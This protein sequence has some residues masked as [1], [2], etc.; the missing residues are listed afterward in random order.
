MQSKSFVRGALLT[1]LIF[2]VHVAVGANTNTNNF[3]FSGPEIFPIDQQIG[4]LHVADM[5]GDGLNDLVVANNLRAKI[6]ILYNLTGKTNLPARPLRLMEINDLPPG[7]RFRIDS[8]PAD[9]RIS[10]M[11]VTDL[12]GDGRPDIAYYGDAKDLIVLYNQGTNGWSEPKRWHVDDGQMNPNTLTA[13]DLNGDGRTD[14]VLLGDNGS[15]YFWAQGA[16]HTLA[17]PVKIPYSGT[18][19]SVQIQDVNGDGKSDLLFVDWDSPTPFRFRLQNAAGELGPEIF[20][21]YPPIRSFLSSN[22]GGGSNNYIVTIAQ[23]SGRAEVSLFESKPAEVLSGA[24]RQGQFQV[25]PLKK[26]DAAQR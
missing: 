8:I 15:A 20:F 23:A 22:L 4:L 24:L 1:A 9:E 19:K 13:G 16:D 6:N 14:L 18:P 7:S 5:D 11:V 2:S 26:T 25:L 12:N 21:K 3:N 10:D 17:E